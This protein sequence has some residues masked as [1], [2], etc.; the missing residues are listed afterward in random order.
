ML[1]RNTFPEWYSSVR[2]SVPI[3]WQDLRF[4]RALG[5][6][7]KNMRA[8]CMSLR[9]K[10]LYEIGDWKLPEKLV[11]NNSDVDLQQERTVY[12]ES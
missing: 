5:S 10:R 8:I 1:V 2:D 11:T 9:T 12:L 7:T 4:L 6:E 3:S